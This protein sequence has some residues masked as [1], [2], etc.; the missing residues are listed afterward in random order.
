M[1]RFRS[2]VDH[3]AVPTIEVVPPARGD[4]TRERILDAAL[5]VLRE[6]GYGGFS[7]QKVARHAGVYQGNI[8]YYWPRR[9]DLVRA[10]A[11]RVID[12]YRRSFMA[13]CGA[14]ADGSDGAGSPEQ[15]ADVL[16]RW[17]MQDAIT[18]DR[19]R[20]L[21]ELWSMANAD[22][23]IALEVARCADEATE[24]LME[25]LGVPQDRPCAQQVRRALRVVG[26][27]AQGLTAVH[28]HRASDDEGLHQLV[29]ALVTLHS[30]VLGSALAACGDGAAR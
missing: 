10:T 14:L 5:A 1:E 12:D 3:V 2:G 16:V 4:G 15:R 30:S 28:G 20:L 27:A 22:G 9:L 29:D 26:V 19:V 6:V 23:T 11:G 7:V 21:P 13:G 18:V 25:L 8:T 17:M 24:A